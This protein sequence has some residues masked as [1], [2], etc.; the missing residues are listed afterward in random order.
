MTIAKADLAQNLADDCGFMKVEATEIAEK[1]LGIIKDSLVRG[2]D[3]MASGFGK[4]AVKSKHARGGRNPQ[5]G[6]ELILD[7]RRL[8]TWR[9]W[10]VL[11]RAV[12]GDGSKGLKR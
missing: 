6:D 10:P 3:V 4:W 12:N 11:K 9:Y 1:L 7:A 8:V 2:E 5:T